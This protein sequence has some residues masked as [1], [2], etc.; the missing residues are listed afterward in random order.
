MILSVGAFYLLQRAQESSPEELTNR[1]LLFGLWYLVV[2]L[3]LILSFILLRNL[4]RLAVERRSGGLGSRFR[5]KLVLTYVG[6][7]LVPGIRPD[8]GDVPLDD[9]ARVTTPAEAVRNG[10]D[11][12]V[13][14]RPIRLADDPAAAVAKI[15]G[16]IAAALA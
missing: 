4:L 14:G 6:L 9:Q 13:I 3:I 15:A 7:T 5:T 10:A 11:Y 8:W 16:E 1:V 2:S 12:L